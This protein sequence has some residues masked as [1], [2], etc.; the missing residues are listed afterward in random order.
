MTKSV[1]PQWYRQGWTLDIQGMSWVENT[2]AEVDFVVRELGL[3]GNERVLDIAC[4]FGRDSL[5]LARRG[6]KVVGI[7]ITE[8]Y[9][10]AAVSQAQSEGL[11]AEF[12]VMDMRDP[13]R[14][15]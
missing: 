1:D 12:I 4:G 3:R 5:E 13:T 2:V 15:T 10:E 6:F 8:V 11:D 9:I 7:D 14:R